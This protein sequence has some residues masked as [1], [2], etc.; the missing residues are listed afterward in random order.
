[1][2]DGK[3][4]VS[5]WTDGKIRSFLPQSGKMYWVINKAHSDMGRNQGGVM[6]ICTTQDCEN[7]LSS[8]TD[9]ELKL[10][11]IGKQVKTC[12]SS[13]KMHSS[14]ITSI[15]MIDCNDTKVASASLDGTII[16]WKLA[17]LQS[18]QKLHHIQIPSGMN[19]DRVH[20]N[21]ILGMAYC[22]NNNSLVCIDINRKLSFLQLDEMEIEKQIEAAYDG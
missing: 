13:Q 9:G 4:I 19:A 3:S 2:A 17:K 1:M 5:G 10:W 18:L 15:K 16:I 11:N 7:V 8:G 21:S 22:A 14:E 6:V 12:Q 20:S